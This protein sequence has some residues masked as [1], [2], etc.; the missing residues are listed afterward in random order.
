MNKA[1]ITCICTRY[2]RS[3]L[4]TLFGYIRLH[5]LH[6]SICLHV[7]LKQT[8]WWNQSCITFGSFA[9]Q[10]RRSNTLISYVTFTKSSVSFCVMNF[11]TLVLSPNAQYA[12]SLLKTC[13]CVNYLLYD[14]IIVACVVPDTT[15]SQCSLS[16]WSRTECE[17][18]SNIV[19]WHTNTS[20]VNAL[21]MNHFVNKWFSM[22]VWS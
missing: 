8:G 19:T 15:H 10:N 22:Q 9:F 11:R 5:V 20:N 6:Y 18:Q 16:A 1:C 21:I 2:S 4:N 14:A 12:Q 13:H 3:C 7:E 17:Q